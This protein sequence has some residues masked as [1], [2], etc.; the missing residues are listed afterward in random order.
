MLATPARPPRALCL[1]YQAAALAVLLVRGS[2]GATCNASSFLYIQTTDFLGADIS[3][4]S[5]SNLAAMHCV[6]LLDLYLS[7]LHVLPLDLRDENMLCEDLH[8]LH[9]ACLS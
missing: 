5:Q 6:L 4:T 2:H 8:G 1:V 9:S 7:N 3:S